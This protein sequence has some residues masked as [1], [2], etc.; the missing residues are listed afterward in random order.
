MNNKETTWKNVFNINRLFILLILFNSFFNSFFNFF[1][2]P[3]FLIK[4]LIMPAFPLSSQAIWTTLC[5]FFITLI[6]LFWTCI[7]LVFTKWKLGFFSLTAL[8][9]KGIDLTIGRIW[10]GFSLPTVGNR[11]NYY[12]FLLTFLFPLLFPFWLLTPFPT[13][14]VVF[15]S[16]SRYSH[17]KSY[18]LFKITI[19]SKTIFKSFFY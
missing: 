5:L 14:V 15:S 13:R 2:I 6:I 3:F 18:S 10:I 17:Q 16:Y 11:V 9:C 4:I 19:H 12:D 8:K 7:S 1:L